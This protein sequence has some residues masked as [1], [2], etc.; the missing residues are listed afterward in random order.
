[1]SADSIN[2]LHQHEFAGRCIQF[3]SLYFTHT[4]SR[5]EVAYTLYSAAKL[6]LT[7]GAYACIGAGRSGHVGLPRALQDPIQ[8]I[9]MQMPMQAYANKSQLRTP[10][11]HAVGSNEIDSCRSCM[12]LRRRTKARAGDSLANSEARDKLRMQCSALPEMAW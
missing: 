2:R 6:P 9:S 3:M 5:E 4:G 11:S 1:M 10:P 12:C 7:P 8:K